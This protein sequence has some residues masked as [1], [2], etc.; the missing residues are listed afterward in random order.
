MRRVQ[1]Q[2]F[3]QVTALKAEPA[4]PTASTY[5]PARVIV[6]AFRKLSTKATAAQIR[7]Y[8]A[9]LKGYPAING[10]MDFSD[11]NQRGIGE[12]GVVIVQWDPAKR[13]FTPVSRLGGA[14]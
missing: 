2:F 10:M 3:S 12:S 8:I 6:D 13:T 14:L 4:G 1:Q 7:D 9:H 5:D 11:G